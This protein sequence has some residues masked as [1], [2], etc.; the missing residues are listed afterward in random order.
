MGTAIDLKRDSFAYLGIKPVEHLAPKR[1]DTVGIGRIDQERAWPGVTFL[2]SIFDGRFTARLYAING[3][4]IHEWPIDFFE[5]NAESEYRYHTL[6]HGAQLMPNGDLIANLDGHGIFRIS[7]CGAIL[8]HN[9][10][11]SHHALS[12]DDAG[13]IWTPMY[14]ETYEPSTLLATEHEVDKVGVFEASTGEL[15]DSIDLAA[16]IEAM[17]LQGLVLANK[18]KARDLLHL[19]DVEVLSASDALA[20]DLFE[21]GDVLLS[22]RQLNQIWVLDGATHA[23]KWWHTGPF[24]SAHDP[25]FQP[26]G[27]I[28]ILDNR[29]GGI[30]RAE[31]NWKGRMGGSRIVRINPLDR[32]HEVVVQSNEGLDLYT[33]FRG[34]HQV[35]P[36]GNVVI[37]ETDAGRAVE[38]T[39]DGKV[40]WE[41]V[42]A[43]DDKSVAWM[44][45]AIRYP[46][47]YTAA[48]S[49]PC[50]G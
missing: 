39:N 19:N 5:V 1:S 50:P 31:N 40:V 48:F 44:M 45:D 29:T 17:G 8:W 33:A 7:R 36:N 4:L 37:A 22:P 10:S 32:T 41:Y 38:V 23:L 25:D 6:I 24:H 13:Q 43:Y 11:R 28:T 30:A 35:L 16:I 34:K 3:Q 46:E 49:E 42:N 15:I 20:F 26:D 21:A 12:F 14:G 2:V 18:E 27:T 47:S 9:S